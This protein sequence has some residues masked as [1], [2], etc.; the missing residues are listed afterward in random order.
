MPENHGTNIFTLTQCSILLSSWN[1]RDLCWFIHFI[2]VCCTAEKQAIELRFGD[3]CRIW[4]DSPETQ[5]P[6]WLNLSSITM[7]GDIMGIWYKLSQSS[8]ED[9]QQ[10]PQNKCSICW[11]CVLFWASFQNWTYIM[12]KVK[13]PPKLCKVTMYELMVKESEGWLAEGKLKCL[14]NS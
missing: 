13:Q 7:W 14:E 2:H 4:T 8:D 6:G 3:W 10:E 9:W 5:W 12:E 1:S 11:G